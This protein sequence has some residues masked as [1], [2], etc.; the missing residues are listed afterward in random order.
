MNETEICD[1]PE[2]MLDLNLMP[3]VPESEGFDDYLK[4]L[5][6][7]QN[8]LEVDL[9]NNS[10]ATEAPA[11]IA[12]S[13]ELPPQLEIEQFQESEFELPET[14]FAFKESV[15]EPEFDFQ[16]QFPAEEESPVFDYSAFNFEQKAV[17]DNAPTTIE[18]VINA[19]IEAPK[20]FE[21][22]SSTEFPKI[23]FEEDLNLLAEQNEPPDV[24]A[25][26]IEFDDETEFPDFIAQ[27]TNPAPDL[28]D[29]TEDFRSVELPDFDLS[30]NSSE[31]QPL[32][33]ENE[34][35]LE[36]PQFENEESSFALPDTFELAASLPDN[37][38]EEPPVDQIVDEPE[39]DFASQTLFEEISNKDDHD[40][41]DELTPTFSETTFLTDLPDLPSPFS[42]SFFKEEA[43]LPQSDE[44]ASTT[45]VVKEWTKPVAEPGE[46]LDENDEISNQYVVFKLNEQLFAFSAANVVEVGH[47][48][49][50]AALPFVPNWMSGVAN[51]RGDIIAVL[52]LR[53]LW[54]L[55]PSEPGA[56]QKMLILR[57]QQEQ[58]LVGLIVDGVSE[59]RYL[60]AHEIQEAD[61]SV[62]APFAAY[63]KGLTGTDLNE[64][65]LLN[66]EEF[67]SAPELRKFV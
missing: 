50:V 26:T 61:N 46:Y 39:T 31:L 55:P 7:L 49:P 34:P 29:F 27:E 35:E 36:T 33:F 45:P 67:L 3:P 37:F 56:R 22:E 19:E 59:M 58:L 40:L 11:I 42:D 1:L 38:F 13:P 23:S 60:A 43:S 65:H 4:I 62:N 64:L 10:T 17:E 32:E 25:E 24:F 66:A 53:R 9:E 30:L 44:P 21:Y 52:D 28:P 14:A 47:P 8:S 18:E 48:L 2:Q 15:P 54:N 41:P 57:S 16:A 6:D 51:L 63:L 5:G 20:T 12:S